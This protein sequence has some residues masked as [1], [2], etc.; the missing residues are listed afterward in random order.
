M[1]DLEF[2]GV[3]LLCLIS[4]QRSNKTSDLPAVIFCV[5]LFGQESCVFQ[6]SSSGQQCILIK[7]HC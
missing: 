4:V 7:K 3:V 2:A 5:V 1:N 6:G